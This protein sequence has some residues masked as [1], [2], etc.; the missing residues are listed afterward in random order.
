MYQEIVNKNKPKEPKIRNL[1]VSFI[2][3]GI[4]G[5]I[6]EFLTDLYGFLFNITRPDA[7]TI[8][9]IT[10]IFIASL[11]TALGFFDNLVSFCKCGLIIP[12]TGFSHS[13]T[14]S[15]LEYKTEG[16]ISGIGSNTFKLAGSVIVYGVVS[17]IIFGLI[18][19][20]LGG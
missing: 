1:I 4:V 5:L 3:G 20:I 16:M 15:C 19:I 14:S 11:F 6:G 18:R 12:I 17:A 8:M 13:V 10:L 2:I 7:I 9:L